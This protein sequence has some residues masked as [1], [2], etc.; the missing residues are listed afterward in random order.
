MPASLC[1]DLT[2]ERNILK[3]RT[4]VSKAV[5]SDSYFVRRTD[6]ISTTARRAA[7]ARRAG[8]AIFF[9][10]DLFFTFTFHFQLVLF[11]TMMFRAARSSIPHWA[12]APTDAWKPCGNYLQRSIFSMIA[13][14]PSD[15]V[16]NTPF[17]ELEKILENHGV[18]SK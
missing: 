10:C 16:G 11:L 4:I 8:D 15:L 5:R 18:D 12:N 17:L 2:Y 14:R 3:P 13:S 7:Q 1:G 9:P 6:A